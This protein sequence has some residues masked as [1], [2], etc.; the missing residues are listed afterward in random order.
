MRSNGYLGRRTVR[1]LL[2]CLGT[3]AAVALL[4]GCNAQVDQ[5]VE[6]SAQ[7][8]VA[9]TFP[10]VSTPQATPR[11]PS[12]RSTDTSQRCVEYG[13]KLKDAERRLAKLKKDG[14][15]PPVDGYDF[16]DDYNQDVAIAEQE[17][18]FYI[19]TLN[20]ECTREPEYTQPDEPTYDPD[21]PDEPE[22]DY[23]P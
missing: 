20:D 3:G 14:P 7:S 8:T 9:T 12:A 16:T 1:Q 15:P 21:P 4:A 2:R 6:S 19:G 18:E 23:G 11:G 22:P 17:I 5:A 13:K 10:A